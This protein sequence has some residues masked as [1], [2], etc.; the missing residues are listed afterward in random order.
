MVGTEYKRIRQ[1]VNMESLASTYY[2]IEFTFIRAIVTFCL[3]QTTREEL[4]GELDSTRHLLQN[5]TEGNVASVS[6]E[7]ER[8]F[9][10]CDAKN[11]DIARHLV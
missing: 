5:C 6:F 3:G 8:E 1:K 4:N 7:N 9:G 10:V 2:S 11:R